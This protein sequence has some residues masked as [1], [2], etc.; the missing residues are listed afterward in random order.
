M[1]SGWVQPTHGSMWI[2]F[3][4]YLCV[5]HC[6]FHIYIIYAASYHNACTYAIASLLAA[7]CDLYP[8]ERFHQYVGT[9]ARSS[10]R[11]FRQENRSWLRTGAHSLCPLTALSFNVIITVTVTVIVML[12]EVVS[13]I[14]ILSVHGSLVEIL[15]FWIFIIY[16]PIV[17]IVMRKAK[18]TL[19]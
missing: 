4:L 6:V 12:M 9:F 14:I 19:P 1:P 2:C 16:I 11:S 5:I 15:Y 7:F 8:C 3:C 18:F 17:I 10:V 13:I